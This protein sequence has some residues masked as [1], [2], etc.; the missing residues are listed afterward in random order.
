M[1]PIPYT[2]RGK[3]YYRDAAYLLCTDNQGPVELII[4]AYFDRWQIEVNHKE[5]KSILGV[6]EAQVRN[7]RSVW[8]QPGLH[9]AAYSALL[10]ASILTY[11]DVHHSDFGN[12]PAW[13]EK[14]KRN[15]CRALVGQLQKIMLEKPE[16]IVQLGLRPPEIAA[17]LSKAA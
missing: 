11:N 16:L 4:Q 2:R 15:S 9:V 8:K 3:R 13:R 7:E 17:I 10:L 1:A 6:G 14:P 12:I 5:E